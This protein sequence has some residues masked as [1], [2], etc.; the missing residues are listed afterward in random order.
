MNSS[1]SVAS[2]GSHSDVSSLLFHPVSL[3]QCQGSL[4]LHR[5]EPAMKHQERVQTLCDVHMHYFG[6]NLQLDYEKF[7]PRD[8]VLVEQQHCGGNTLHV[9]REKIMPGSEFL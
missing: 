7:D 8:E 2:D 9:F 5:V 3:W 1:A 6:S 4:M